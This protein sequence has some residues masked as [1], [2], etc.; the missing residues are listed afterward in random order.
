MSRCTE[1]G[2]YIRHSSGFD[3]CTSN[4]D[5]VARAKEAASYLVWTTDGCPSL[6]RLR[7]LEALETL[8][9]AYSLS[10]VAVED[11]LWRALHRALLS[12]A[13]MKASRGGKND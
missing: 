6:D 12:A 9:L 7:G 13:G 4:T 8:R 1:A 11:T 5:T 10:L 2:A 3:G